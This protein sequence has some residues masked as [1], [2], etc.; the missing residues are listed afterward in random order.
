MAQRVPNPPPPAAAASLP[1]VVCD[2]N[3]PHPPLTSSRLPNND[4]WYCRSTCLTGSAP[5]RLKG[6][7]FP[8]YGNGKTNLEPNPIHEKYSKDYLVDENGFRR[9]TQG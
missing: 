1:F 5:C 2:L 9:Q 4:C 3:S 8:W 7:H 6:C